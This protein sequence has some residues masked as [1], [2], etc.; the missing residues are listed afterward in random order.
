MLQASKRNLTYRQ[1][2]PIQDLKNY[3]RDGELQMTTQQISVVECEVAIQRS[4]RTFPGLWKSKLHRVRNAA[5][6]SDDI[7][8]RRKIVVRTASNSLVTRLRRNPD[9]CGGAFRS[10]VAS[11]YASASL[12]LTGCAMNSAFTTVWPPWEQRLSG[13]KREG[14]TLSEALW[15]E[16]I[17]K[18]NKADKGRERFFYL[19]KFLWK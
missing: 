5:E 12:G 2:K 9:S 11:Q 4:I 1:S 14:K 18:N 16:D 19:K 15:Y 3:L 8:V 13:S 17:I 7:E 10:H 6:T